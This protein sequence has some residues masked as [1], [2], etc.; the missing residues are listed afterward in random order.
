M[1]SVVGVVLCCVAMLCCC[2]VVVAEVDVMHNAIKKTKQNNKRKTNKNI[3]RMRVLFWLVVVVVVCV[4]GA[5]RGVELSER[6]DSLQAGEHVIIVAC[7]N[8]FGPCSSNGPAQ[9]ME[10]L[11]KGLPVVVFPISWGGV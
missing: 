11:V 10:E 3:K 1:C 2:V 5:V 8:A 4:V 7:G 9:Q 6:L